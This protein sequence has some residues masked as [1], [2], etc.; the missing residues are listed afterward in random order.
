MVE[1]MEYCTIFVY[2]AEGIPREDVATM[3]AYG[4]DCC[5][6]AEKHALTRTQLG[7]LAR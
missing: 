3:V 4:L 5:K 6:R 1:V 2:K 7:N